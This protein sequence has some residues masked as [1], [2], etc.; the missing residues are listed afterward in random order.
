MRSNGIEARG[1]P[2]LSVIIMDAR[3]EEGGIHWRH[4][5]GM[6]LLVIEIHQIVELTGT[7]SERA[8]LGVYGCSLDEAMPVDK[9]V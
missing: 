3:V 6:T 8:I 1:H 7:S 9:E 2:R 5:W 4:I